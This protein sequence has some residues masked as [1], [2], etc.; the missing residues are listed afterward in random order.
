MAILHLRCQWLTLKGIQPLT[1]SPELAC[2]ILGQCF[3]CLCEPLE[4]NVLLLLVGVGGLSRSSPRLCRIA[5]SNTGCSVI[6][7]SCPVASG[8]VAIVE[9]A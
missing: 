8:A 2:H 3:D 9:Y 1:E 7:V 6:G 4:F 5:L